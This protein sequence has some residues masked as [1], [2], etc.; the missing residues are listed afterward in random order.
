MLK[1]LASVAFGV[2]F[3]A[4][5]VLYTGYGRQYISVPNARLIFIGSGGAALILNLFAYRQNKSN[6]LFTF[7]YWTGSLVL[8]TGLIFLLMRWPYHQYILLAGLGITGISFFMTPEMSEPSKDEGILD[9]FDDD[10]KL[11]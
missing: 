8:F 5:I 4:G 1:R 9:D 2:A 7:L 11:S 6:P 10:T 3:L